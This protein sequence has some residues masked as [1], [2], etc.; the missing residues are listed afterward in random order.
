MSTAELAGPPG[1]W[2]HLPVP[3]NAAAAVRIAAARYAGVDLDDAT[4]ERIALVVLEC[5]D[6]E[7]G[8]RQGIDPRMWDQQ[9]VRDSLR[10]HQRRA[11]FVE[12]ADK[13]MIPVAWPRERIVR[14]PGPYGAMTS[15]E[16]SVPVRLVIP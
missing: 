15:V 7:H 5:A 16:L 9:E 14:T 10:Q 11:L 1:E 4:A 6:G 2:P 13:G 8:I 3:R 12:L